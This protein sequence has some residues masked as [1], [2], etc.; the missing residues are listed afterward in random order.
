MKV[1]FVVLRTLEQSLSY[2]RLRLKAL[3]AGNQHI[4]KLLP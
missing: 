3:E 4:I 2:D 1:F